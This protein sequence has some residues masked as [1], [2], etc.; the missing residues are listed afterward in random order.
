MIHLFAIYKPNHL[1]NKH[2]PQI[3]RIFLIL[4]F[5]HPGKD[6]FLKVT[7]SLNRFS[8]LTLDHRQNFLSSTSHTMDTITTRRGRPQTKL[9]LSESNALT[10]R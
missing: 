1:H 8:L 4:N 7:N 6:G 5:I 2:F 3:C 10:M 9:R